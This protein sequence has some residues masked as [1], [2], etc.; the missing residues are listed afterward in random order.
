VATLVIPDGSAEELSGEEP[1]SPA[2][3][4]IAAAFSRGA[5]SIV[6]VADPAL[7]ANRFLG[8]A[9]NAVAAVRLL[10]PGSQPVVFDEFHHGLGPRDQPLWLVTRPGFGPVAAALLAT[11]LLVVWRQGTRL[12]P[13]IADRPVDRRGIGEYLDAMGNLLSQG[14]GDKRAIVA[15]VRA[16]IAR[17]LALRAGLPPE[18][19]D[20]DRLDTALVRCDPVR[21]RAVVGTL[22]DVD[23]LLAEDR[24]T[25]ARTLETLRRLSQCL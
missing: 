13:P 22:R 7:F 19:A 3:R 12:G 16:G 1:G 10:A 23:R 11:V 15:D 6:V 25:T 17:E 21:A 8:Q 20:L 4:V 9:D 24:W 18:E 5:G 2:P 14:G